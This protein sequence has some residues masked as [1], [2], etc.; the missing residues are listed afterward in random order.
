MQAV[1]EL[2]LRIKRMILLFI[3]SLLE[4]LQFCY[5][6]ICKRLEHLSYNET[7]ADRID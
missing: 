1:A 3:V 6:S 7:K 2:F 4:K 5:Y